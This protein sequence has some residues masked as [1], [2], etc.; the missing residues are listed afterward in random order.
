MMGLFKSTLGAKSGGPMEGNSIM[1]SRCSPSALFVGPPEFSQQNSSKFPISS[2]IT[3]I[4]AS[5]GGP[6]LEP[7]LE[8]VEMFDKDSGFSTH[9]LP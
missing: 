7:V 1:S 3:H 9:Y 2:Q 4:S 6:H 5:Q 8:I